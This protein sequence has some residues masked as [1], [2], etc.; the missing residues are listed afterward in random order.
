MQ[1]KV[2]KGF[3]QNAIELIQNGATVISN[4]VMGDYK[5]T[6]PENLWDATIKQFNDA[7][8][9]YAEEVP[10]TELQ[11]LYTIISKQIPAAQKLKDSMTQGYT[12]ELTLKNL[13]IKKDILEAAIAVL[14]GIGDSAVLAEEVY[15]KAQEW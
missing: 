14:E 6:L 5:G 2:K 10:L 7:I 12:G 8:T 1:A 4:K 11:R 13:T 15:K 3:L 9:Y